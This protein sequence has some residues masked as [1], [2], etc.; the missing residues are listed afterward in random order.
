MKPVDIINEY[1]KQIK[2]AGQFS[3]PGPST[4]SNYNRD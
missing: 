3:Y 4:K 1:K 2:P